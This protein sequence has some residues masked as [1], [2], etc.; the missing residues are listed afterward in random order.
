MLQQASYLE[1]GPLTFMLPLYLH[2]NKK[3]DYD[4]MM[5]IILYPG[6]GDRGHRFRNLVSKFHIVFKVFISRML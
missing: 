3:S 2:V 6:P 5:M 4:M 1:G